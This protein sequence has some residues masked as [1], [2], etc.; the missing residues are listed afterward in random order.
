MDNELMQL[1]VIAILILL[2]YGEMDK[3]PPAH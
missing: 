1:L 3:Q 2:A